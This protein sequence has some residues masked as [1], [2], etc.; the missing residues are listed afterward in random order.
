[1]TTLTLQD[2]ADLAKVQRPVV[3]MW[4]KRPM[5]RGVSI[6]FPDPV[7]TVDGVARFS[8]D[9]VVAWL[10]RTGRG[11]NPEHDYDAPAVSP[12]DDATREDVVTLLCWH[13]L[14]GE[15]LTG[16]SHADLMR[17]ADQ[18]D[19]ENTV[20][21]DEIRALR[22][23][24][25]VLGYVDDLVEASR[26]PSDALQRV[27]A[28]RLK[29]REE[30]RELTDDAVKL[31]RCMVEAAAVYLEQDRVLLRAE[32]STVALDVAEACELDVVS[33]DRALRRRA[34]IR[35]IHVRESAVSASVSAL[36]LVGLDIADTLD[37]VD[38]A[39]LDLP[40]GDVAI[41]IGSAAALSDELAGPMQNRRAEALRVGNLVAAVRL[42]RGLWR[43]AHR[44]NL[45]VWVCAGGAQAQ[46]PWVADLGAVE[47]IELTDVAADV[48]G[49]LAQT[50]DRA[51]RYAR[52]TQLST[53]LAGAAVVPRGVRAVRLRGHDEAEHVERVH[54]ATLVTTTPLPTLD[55]LVSKSPGRMHL[56]HR[57]LAELQSGKRLTMK[58]GRRIDVSDGSP[59]GT[60]RVLP[61]E[62]VG[63]LALDPI[64]AEAKYP[65]AVRTE[66]G[67]VIFLEKPRPRASVD[68]IG[69]A[70]VACPARILRLDE[71]AEV[72]PLVLATLINETAFAGS[73][74]QT[75]TVPVLPR[76]EAERLEAALA[77]ADEYEQQASRR[78][79]AARE[80][81]TSL[82]NGVAAGALTLDV[83]HTVPGM[84]G[85]T[86]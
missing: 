76:A 82:I 55:V 13:V 30:L 52:R 9:E 41:L 17:L 23:S 85:P 73:E 75:W 20:L 25:A 68:R 77:R 22:V 35:G 11:N 16:R 53:V 71:S 37:G 65:R 28:G 63:R 70:M 29:R 45:A 44:Q 69:G 10:A 43:E 42:P 84:T 34:V 31:L 12:P 8:R 51:F 32:G 54:R 48:A 27:E 72:G 5:V 50:E 14:T 83:E 57:S 56:A 60:V 6:P 19:P 47:H 7:D 86:K 62:V 24:R 49:A 40:P 59:Q 81:K 18:F 46:H 74:W 2:V 39:V 21:A 15:D 38:D 4:R 61:E 1:M 26:G 64:D 3:S 78:V 33:N 67:D 79:E 58:R 36:S 80:L 66:P